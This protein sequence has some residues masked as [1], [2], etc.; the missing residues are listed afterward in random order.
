MLGKAVILLALLAIVGCSKQAESSAA[1]GVDFKVDRLFTH[2]RC[3]VY[4]F[5]DSG[6]DRYFT[7]CEGMDAAS[8]TAWSESCGKNCRRRVGVSGGAAP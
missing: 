8:D 7:R 4:R 6:S 1:A 3:T 2:D 5:Q